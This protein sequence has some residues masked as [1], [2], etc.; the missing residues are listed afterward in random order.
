MK[1]IYLT[2][3][4]VLVS[5][6]CYSQEKEEIQ[7]KLSATVYSAN[8]ENASAEV[9]SFL[10]SNNL[11][12]RQMTSSR[13]RLFV[14]FFCQ[15]N[16]YHEFEKMLPNWGYL[17]QKDM[18]SSYNYKERDEISMELEYKKRRKTAYEKEIVSMSE[19]DERYYSYWEEIRQIEK[20]IFELEKQLESNKVQYKYFVSLTLRDD[21]YDMTERSINWVNMPGVSTEWL[22][23]E[24]PLN[25]LS[26]EQYWGYSI[27]YMF[28]RGKT[29]ANIGAMKEISG[30][31]ADSSRFQEL[32][33][34]GF[35]QDFYS[36]Y[37]GRGK[38][39]FF[40]L[41]TG[42]NIGGL[43][44]TADKRNKTMFYLTPFL[45]IELFKNK[46][47]LLDN[48]VGYFVPFA[49]NRNLRGII[50][51]ASFNFVF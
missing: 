26:A 30:E 19:K 41:Y 6:F 11:E 33:L 47:I 46:Y 35:G 25:S 27:K 38:H 29:Y 5:V 44:A 37:L 13:N 43:F 7:I 42:Y 14:Q 51:S 10:E 20:Q 17:S 18:E 4:A 40:N 21:T 16:L 24:S 48:R 23:T 34:F 1:K 3:F 12:I 49:H 15:E 28:T 36:K 45:G 9:E 22:F 2:L 50:Y 32:F 39:K 31:P 8:F